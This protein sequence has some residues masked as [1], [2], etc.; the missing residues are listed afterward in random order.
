LSD[1]PARTDLPVEDVID[2]LRAAL[3]RSASAVLVA[4]PGAGKTTL[5]PLRL[6]DEP[7]ARG[8]RIVML[9][10]R[11]LAARAAARRMAAMLGEEPGATVGYQT[12]DERRIG[13]ST[14][15]EVLT[16]GILTRRLQNDPTL[17]GT[18]L[19]IFDEVHERN[20]PTDLGLAF[21]LDARRTLGSSV[22]VL[23]M[24]AT[25]QVSTF[26]SVLGGDT[27]ADVPV[28]SSDGRMHPVDVRFVPRSRDE[29]L[30]N[31]VT[32]AVTAAM[33]E[34]DGDVLVFLPGVGEINRCAES[35]RAVLPPGVRVHRLAGA[36]PFDEQDAALAPSEPGTRRVVLSTDI[37][38]SSLTVDGVRIVVDVGLA[39]VP[40]LD[41]R[42]GLTEIV[43]VTS[44]RASADQRSGRAG[45]TEPG[46]AYRL[47]SR[48]EDA[49]RLPHLP[50]EITQ[51]DLCGPA[52]EIAAW[53]T[54]HHELGLPDPLPR[55]ALESA[56]D[57]LRM[58]H[59]IDADGRPTQ[60][61]RDVLRL[62]LHPRLG[63]MVARSTGSPQRAWLAC[64]L[65]ALLEE[66]DIMRGRPDD[67]P[68]DLAL[69]ARIVLGLDSHDAADMGGVRR[70]RDAARDIAR[71]AGI[72]A[73][74]PLGTDDVDLLAGPVLLAAYPDRLAIARQSA[75][76][77]VM[78]SGS[79]A[80][81]PQRDPLASERFVV[82][83]DIDGGRGSARLRRG[84]GID[85][86]TIAGVLGDDMRTEETLL[87]DKQRNDLVLR[88]VRSVGSLRIDEH[89][90]PAPAGDATTAALLERV[91][92]TSLGVLGGSEAADSLR[93]RVAFLRH[94]TGDAWP[95]LSRRA[96]LASVADWL[97][98]YLP[99]A[100]CRADLERVDLMMVM[101]AELGWDRS[102]EL[103]RLAPHSFTPQRGRPASIDYS[104]PAH[105]TVSVRVQHMFGTAVHPAV[106]DGRVP[107]RF[108]LLSP[109]DRPIQVTSDLPGFWSGSWAD[110]RKDMAGRYPKHDWPVDPNA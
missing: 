22:K 93:A 31:S 96:M 56:T 99:G 104:D 34:D 41:V 6:L 24:S 28:V 69:R 78:R 89:D 61:G 75:G 36:L 15:V 67:L 37:A 8:K 45:R 90:M 25:P 46:V 80:A 14:R 54:P 82:A 58:L 63:T 29:R 76:Q 108:R 5:V 70:V 66:R 60:Q 105:P 44:S 20:V 47:W 101:Q 35:L 91:R 94:H 21:L 16:E 59:L 106:L 13:A 12:R 43:T 40:R 48:M 103:E 17:E 19:V 33:R 10:P 71:R 81:C 52:L 65:A 84:V 98:P 72:G 95:D 102:T 86:D 97:V 74:T 51:V 38:E 107:L 3:N 73:D 18:A 100:T 85:P 79:G 53:G 87:W 26:V 2:D 9:E 110:V 64:V 39:R 83:A 1:R 7:W 32:A 55:R 27:P 23:A 109:A 77:F 49:T 50:A 68:A 92:D 30:E 88:R 57:V 62:P 11:R 42:T 4:P